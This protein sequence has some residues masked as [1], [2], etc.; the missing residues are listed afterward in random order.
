ML[1]LGQVAAWF[2]L[3]SLIGSF[4]KPITLATWVSI[5]MLSSITGYVLAKMYNRYE[6]HYAECLKRLAG[7]IRFNEKYLIENGI[8]YDDFIG[9]SNSCSDLSRYAH[10]L[11][12]KRTML[13]WYKHFTVIL[14]CSFILLKL[15]IDTCKVFRQYQKEILEA[16]EITKR[17]RKYDE[18][19]SM[20]QAL[21][22]YYDTYVTGDSP[23]ITKVDGSNDVDRLSSLLITVVSA[24]AQAMNC[25]PV[26]KPVHKAPVRVSVRHLAADDVVEVEA[27]NV[28]DNVAE[29]KVDNV[30]DAV[31]EQQRSKTPD[32]T[33]MLGGCIRH[34]CD[35]G[36]KCTDGEKCEKCHNLT[37]EEVEANHE[38]WLQNL[39]SNVHEHDEDKENP[40]PVFKLIINTADE[41]CQHYGR[42]CKFLDVESKCPFE[43][44]TMYAAAHG[45]DL[46]QRSCAL[47]CARLVRLHL[48]Q[49]PTYDKCVCEACQNVAASN[50]S[51]EKNE[52]EFVA[53]P[54]A[55]PEPTVQS[56]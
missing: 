2:T 27:E 23:F 33:S 16:V 41:R 11:N 52:L 5:S 44:S 54:V 32:L 3:V 4:S 45:C 51:V 18:H 20:V 30:V 17:L 28:A 37:A 29:E 10:Y 34:A 42:M 9:N 38:A 31:V 1:H 48:A 55:E 36:V 19:H 15:P 6:S 39:V 46:T 47:G 35:I 21:M 7:E 56:D 53:E 49:F 13:N 26:E 14:N 50:T 8:P 12:D 24:F 25:K 43:L 40:R 22:Y